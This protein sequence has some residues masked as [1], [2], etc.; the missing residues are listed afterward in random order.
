MDE[1]PKRV[2][3]RPFTPGNGGRPKGARN[4]LG[5]AFVAA[6][7]ADFENNGIDAI[8]RVCEDKPSDYLKVIAGLLPKEL[9][10]EGGEPLMSGLTIS[11]VK[12][13]KK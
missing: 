12:P 2:I 6:L 13:E 5:E 11:F 3:G 4:K 8:R 10:G 1:Q 7:L 9:T